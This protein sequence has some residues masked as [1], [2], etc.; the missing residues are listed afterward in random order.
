LDAGV[1]G[2]PQRFF[3]LLDRYGY[4]GLSYLEACLRLAD[5]RASEAAVEGSTP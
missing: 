1:S 3:G 4:W 2:V 5:H